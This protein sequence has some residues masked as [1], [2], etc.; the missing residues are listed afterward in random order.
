[1]SDV[2]KSKLKSWQQPAEEE[3]G[4]RHINERKA[5]AFHDM[6]SDVRMWINHAW[7][8]SSK[9]EENWQD[10]A[11]WRY[12]VANAQEETK[13]AYERLDRYYKGQEAA[14]QTRHNMAVW[15]RDRR[16][17]EASNG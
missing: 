2:V 9:G 12:K 10:G 6:L 13:R 14:I 1:M 5:K 11:M 8:E 4:N 16:T 3:T 15:H 17:K 7:A